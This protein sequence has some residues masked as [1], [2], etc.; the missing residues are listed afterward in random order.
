[1][2]SGVESPAV[3]DSDASN[4]GPESHQ[5]ISGRNINPAKLAAML[6]T[7]F[8]IGAYEIQV[9]QLTT[10]SSPPKLSAAVDMSTQVVSNVYNIR[11]PRRVSLNEF[12]QCRS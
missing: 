6:R 10:V 12:L 9:S 5:Q 7:K 8:G 3:Y 11:A 2:G 1:M 4:N